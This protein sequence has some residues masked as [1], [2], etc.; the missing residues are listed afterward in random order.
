MERLKTWWA[1]LYRQRWML[2][3]TLLCVGYL[4]ARHADQIGVLVLKLV[5]LTGAFLV[6]YYGDRAAAPYARPDDMIE[7]MRNAATPMESAAWAQVAAAAMQRR[8]VI[9]AGAMIAGA[10]AI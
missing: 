8:S 3:V 9:V 1:N 6:G 4:F 7:R 10:L 2:A 5:L